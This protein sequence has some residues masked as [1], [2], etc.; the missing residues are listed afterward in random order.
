MEDTTTPVPTLPGPLVGYRVRI[1]CPVCDSA[2]GLR[3]DGMVGSHTWYKPQ[4]GWVRGCSGVGKPPRYKSTNQPIVPASPPV[5]VTEHATGMSGGGMNVRPDDP[6]IE[7][8]YPLAVWIAHRQRDGGRVYR[9][10]I[11][12]VDDWEEVPRVD[13]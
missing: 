2:T 3:T 13:E 4:V 7:R 1:E 8:V 6:E 9:R 12:V 10:R 11:V 5:T